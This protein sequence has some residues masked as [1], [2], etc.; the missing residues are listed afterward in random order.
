M[1]VVA[2]RARPF[3][4]ALL[5]ALPLVAQAETK[6]TPDSVPAQEPTDAKDQRPSDFARFVLT[7]NGGHFDT[8]V[9]TYRRDDGVT[10]RF[11]AAVHIADGAHYAELQKR[12]A[13]CGRLLYEL[14]GPEDYRPKKGEARDG[15]VSMLQ[16]GMKTGLELEFQLDGIDYATEN[17]VH[18]DMTPQEFA[19][20]ME[21]RGES[22]LMMMFTAGMNAQRELMEKAEKA[23]EDGT[24]APKEKPVDLVAAFRSGEGRHQLRLQLA[25]Q[26]ESLEAM[27]AGASTTLLEGR[28]EKCLQVLQREIAN[29]Q[30]DL[31]IYYG[32]AHLSHMERR[33]CD[34]LGFHKVDHEWLVAWDCT[35]RADPKIDREVW[36]QR[37][38]AKTEIAALQLLVGEWLAVS[39]AKNTVPTRAQL[40]EHLE[41]SKADAKK[42]AAFATTDPWGRDYEILVIDFGC[43]VRC[44]GEDGLPDTSD[45]L[46][47]L[48]AKAWRRRPPAGI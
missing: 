27:S 20:S 39:G 28:N 36:R 25:Q 7:E 12:F 47:A 15:F 1:F 34:D 46:R 4:I 8:A 23:A 9:T 22:L 10:V 43:D 16:N 35:K 37:R 30:K 18:A 24:E 33:L 44:L 19:S 2:S 14:V 45:D 38:K 17:F 5:S 21:E 3:L 32:A 42:R 29:G 6:P 11:F 31:G 40:E 26:L 13:G 48:S 41:R